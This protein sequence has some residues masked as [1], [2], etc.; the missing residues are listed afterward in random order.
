MHQNEP[1][2]TKSGEVE[3]I[4]EYVTR[5][6][7]ASTRC[8][9]TDKNLEIKLQIVFGCISKRVRRKALSEDISLDDLV[10]FARAVELSSVQAEV[11]E[12]EKSEGLVNKLHRPGV[13]SKLHHS[14]KDVEQNNTGKKECFSCGG[15][16]PHDGGGK[17]C[18]AYGKTCN[19]CTKLNHFGRFCKSN[20][21]NAQNGSKIN[22]VVTKDGGVIESESD[23]SSGDEYVYSN[24]EISDKRSANI[25]LKIEGQLIKFQIDTRGNGQHLR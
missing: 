20:S 16:F 17:N 21:S 15:K 9:F 2:V 6:K 10:K 8:E 24:S 5:L 18:P 1:S 22:M 13:Y 23:V 4:D 12:D 7:E 14:N 19:R 25:S 11:I 3:T